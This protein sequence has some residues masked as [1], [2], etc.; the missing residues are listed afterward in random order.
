M[1]WSFDADVEGL[2]FDR[3]QDVGCRGARR[4]RAQD[5]RNYEVAKDRFH[6]IAPARISA[7]RSSNSPLARR[8]YKPVNNQAPTMIAT[9]SGQPILMMLVAERRWGANAAMRM[10]VKYGTRVAAVRQATNLRRRDTK[11]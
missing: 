6:T 8:M 7:V 3:L 5:R 1:P 2:L 4:Y 9:P 10:N 11:S